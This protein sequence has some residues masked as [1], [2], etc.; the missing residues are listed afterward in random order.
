[1]SYAL[2][3]QRPAPVIEIYQ[4]E[5]V[6]FPDVVAAR[7]AVLEYYQTLPSAS[8]PKKEQFSQ[9]D[10]DLLTRKF[11]DFCNGEIPNERLMNRYMGYL[12]ANYAHRT[13]VKY[14]TYARHVCKQLIRQMVNPDLSDREYRYAAALKEAVM[15]AATVKNPRKKKKVADEGSVYAHGKRLTPEEAQTIL[16]HIDMS[17]LR[18]KRDAAL[19][20]S[21]FATGQRLSEMGRI[22]RKSIKETKNGVFSVTVRSKG[23]KYEPVAID[24]SAVRAIESYVKAY[25][26]C[27]GAGDPRIIGEEDVVWRA[28][29]RS[30]K[31]SSRA[32]GMS[33]RSL[34]DIVKRRSLAPDPECKR[35][36]IQPHDIRRTVAAWMDAFDVPENAIQK[37]FHHETI[38]QTRAYIAPL[39][40]VSEQNVFAYGLKLRLRAPGIGPTLNGEGL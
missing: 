12:M 14:M 16:D 10:A 25:N 1:M 23:N 22:T 31:P 15:N 35:Y 5:I 21:W 4:P 39:T 37:Q 34:S 26:D 9:R 20:L 28:L 18:G 3:Q 32:T 11:V 29:T 36:L 17:T 8:N 13:I 38:V 7:E 33:T 30:D 40:D 24:I 6:W 19:L 27:L 2:V